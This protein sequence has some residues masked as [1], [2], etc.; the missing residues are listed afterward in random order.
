VT[1]PEYQFISTL[2]PFQRADGYV[3]YPKPEEIG[4][5]AK[6]IVEA[7]G[8]KKQPYKLVREEFEKQKYTDVEPLADAVLFKYRSAAIRYLVMTEIEK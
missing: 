6:L 8:S 4:A 5:V 1:A 2:S 3:G 7:T